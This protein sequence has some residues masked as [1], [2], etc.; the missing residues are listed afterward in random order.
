MFRSLEQIHDLGVR[1]VLNKIYFDMVSLSI[2]YKEYEY[3]D[4]AAYYAKKTIM[5]SGF[6]QFKINASELYNCFYYIM[7]LSEFKLSKKDEILLK[8]TSLDVNGYVRLLRKLSTG[9]LPLTELDRFIKLITKY[10]YIEDSLL[11][12]LG[13][14]SVN[15]NRL[16][17]REKRISIDKLEK[18]GTIRF[19]RSIITHYVREIASEIRETHEEDR[20][21]KKRQRNN[22][23]P[24][25]NIGVN[26]QDKNKE[27]DKNKDNSIVKP[28]LYA[29]GGYALAKFLS[30]KDKNDK[31]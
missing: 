18:Y 2:M 31:K 9:S 4:N 5:H 12:A 16:S 27:K 24:D 14:L 30:G 8:R 21:E 26:P 11:R 25:D 15:W 13:R 22:K 23:R 3:S 28:T 20:K 7:N 6:N 19:R 1:K 29:L 17:I 10:L